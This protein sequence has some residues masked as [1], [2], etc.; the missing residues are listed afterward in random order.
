MFNGILAGDTIPQELNERH[1][2]P[3][4][5]KEDK[6]AFATTQGYPLQVQ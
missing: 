2:I 5:K 1:V 4:F 6:N 3:V